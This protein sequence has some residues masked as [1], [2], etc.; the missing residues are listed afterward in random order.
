MSTEPDTQPK[1]RAER[2]TELVQMAYDVLH[3]SCPTTQRADY[4]DPAVARAIAMGYLELALVP[5]SIW[6]M[7]DQ[8]D[9]WDPTDVGPVPCPDDAE[10]VAS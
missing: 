1:T 6:D 2:R 9:P 10:G 5:T 4:I 8:P 3:R 7:S